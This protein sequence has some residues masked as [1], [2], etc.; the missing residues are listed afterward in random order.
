MAEADDADAGG[1][2]EPRAGEHIDARPFGRDAVCDALIDATIAFIMEE[3]LDVS[4]RRIAARAGVNHGLVHAYFE[5]KQGLLSAAVDAINQR[6]SLE[7]DDDGFPPPDLASRRGGELARA[8]ARIQLDQGKDLGSSNPISS[9]WRA[10]LA[11]SRPD[12][13]STE[14]DTMVAT[15]SALGLGWALFADHLSDL[16]GVDTEQR[17]AL[18]T[19]VSSV[20]AQ[21]GGLPWPSPEV[22]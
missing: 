21:L 19:H 5:N 9:A 14:I 4:I 12:L 1:L 13:T 16:L 11:S 7:V 20:I 2:I 18:D 15:A 3:G 8:V 22:R 17:L 10:A 6:A